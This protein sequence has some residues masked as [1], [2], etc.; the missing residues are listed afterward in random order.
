MTLGASLCLSIPGNALAATG[1]I[2]IVGTDI[3]YYIVSKTTLKNARNAC[4]VD[5]DLMKVVENN[6][7]K[8]SCHIKSLAKKN[9]T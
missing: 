7:K 1:E 2:I 3:G 5:Q 4:N 6:R 9:S 8:F